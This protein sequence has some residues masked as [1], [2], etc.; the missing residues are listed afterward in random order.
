[1]FSDGDRAGFTRDDRIG[2]ARLGGTGHNILRNSRRPGRHLR[3]AFPGKNLF[4]PGR[5]LICSTRIWG[6]LRRARIGGPVEI[7]H[8]P[9]RHVLGCLGRRLLE[10]GIEAPLLLAGYRIERDDRRKRRTDIHGVVKDQRRDLVGGLVGPCN[11]ELGYIVRGYL[12]ERRITLT[13]GGPPV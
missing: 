2:I 13:I 5:R 10:I 7:A 9:A 1:M 4:L 3:I 12:F 6:L 11:L 8:P